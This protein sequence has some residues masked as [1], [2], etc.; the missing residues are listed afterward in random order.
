MIL[1]LQLHI[2]FYIYSH[3]CY[4]SPTHNDELILDVKNVHLTGYNNN[5]EDNREYDF[6]LDNA[7]PLHEVFKDNIELADKISLH[8]LIDLEHLLNNEELEK[9]V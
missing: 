6:I 2:T 5:V 8:D 9:E 4:T 7:I 3:T 1:F